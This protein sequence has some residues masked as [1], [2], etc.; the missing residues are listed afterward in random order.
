[1]IVLYSVFPVAGAICK[2]ILVAEIQ[3][4]SDVTYRIYDWD[5]T[6]TNGK[7]RDLHTE[8]AVDAIDYA[9][10]DDYRINF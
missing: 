7:S 4:T 6:D 1:M 9:Y 5:R 2:D 10:H 8:L 3:Q